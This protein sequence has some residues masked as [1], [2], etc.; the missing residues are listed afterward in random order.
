MDDIAGIN[1][2]IM[3]LMIFNQICHAATDGVKNILIVSLLPAFVGFEI[4][5]KF[6][7]A[8]AD[9]PGQFPFCGIAVL[10]DDLSDGSGVNLRELD[11]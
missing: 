10:A 6:R 9:S 1:N 7:I 5:L 3:E 8:G 11:V 2:L 4:C